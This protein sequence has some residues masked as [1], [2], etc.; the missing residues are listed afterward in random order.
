M[1]RGLL[2]A[3]NPGALRYD[4]TFDVVTRRGGRRDPIVQAFLDDLTQAHGGDAA[5]A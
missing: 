4:V 1:K 3:L 2:K 5:H